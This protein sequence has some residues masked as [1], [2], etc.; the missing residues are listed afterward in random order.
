[1]IDYL[2]LHRIYPNGDPED[3]NLRD[4]DTTKASILIEGLK[5]AIAYK[6]GDKSA[7]R[8]VKITVEERVVDV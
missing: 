3:N 6:Q 7:A 8:A 1:M 4:E 5:Q 2:N